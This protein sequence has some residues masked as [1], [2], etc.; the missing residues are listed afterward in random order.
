[1]LE[2]ARKPL[3][4]FLSHILIPTKCARRQLRIQLCSLFKTRLQKQSPNNPPRCKSAVCVHERELPLG[5]LF[6]FWKTFSVT[7]TSRAGPILIFFSPRMN[8]G[9]CKNPVTQ[10]TKARAKGARAQE[11]PQHPQV[12]TNKGGRTEKNTTGQRRVNTGNERPAGSPKNDK[13][14]R[15]QPQLQS[16]WSVRT[17][18]LK[19]SAGSSWVTQKHKT[20]DACR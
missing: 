1:M 2:C 16:I 19:S 15:A 6:S 11:S 14:S 4:T 10:G 17:A 3:S 18:Q 7:N 9:Q 20:R 5:Q 13:R 8:G 12:R